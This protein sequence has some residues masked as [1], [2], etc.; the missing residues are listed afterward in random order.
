MDAKTVFWAL[1]AIYYAIVA[2]RL[3]RAAFRR[4][5]QMHKKML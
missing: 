1:V 2:V 3:V 5:G 4:R